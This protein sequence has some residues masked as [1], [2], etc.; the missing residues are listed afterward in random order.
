[1]KK[2][3][4]SSFTPVLIYF[5]LTLPKICSAQITNPIPEQIQK[6]QLSVGLQKIV[7]IPKNGTGKIRTARLNFLTNAGDGSKRLFVNEI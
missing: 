6:S 2:S 7:Q 5:L 4:I 1:M 3:F